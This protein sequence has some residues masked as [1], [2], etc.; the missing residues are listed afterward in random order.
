MARFRRVSR[1]SVILQISALT[2][3]LAGLIVTATAQSGKRLAALANPIM[4]AHDTTEHDTQASVAVVKVPGTSIVVSA[5]TNT[6]IYNLNAHKVGWSRSTD[7]G[8]TWTDQGHL[9][10][11]AN[12][13]GGEPVLAR[14]ATSGRIYLVTEA[15]AH[16]G[17]QVFRS[18]DNGATWLAPVNAFP[19]FTGD[20]FL[21]TPWIAVDNAVGT[22]QGN[23]YVIAKNIPGGGGGSQPAGSYVTRST[24][25]GATW[26]TAQSMTSIW[27]G[28][29]VAVGPDHTVYTFGWA[30]L[31]P[32]AIRLRRSTDFG[33]TFGS[34]ITVATL[35]GTSVDGDLGLS[36]GFKTNSNPHL[37]IDP[38]DN[39]LN[40]FY[41]DKNG[42]DKANI[43]VVSSGN[44]GLNWD[45][46]AFQI[47]NDTTGRDQ[48]NPSVAWTPDGRHIMVSW[49]DRR[50]DPG[51]SLIE[52]WGAIA[53][54][55]LDGE[56]CTLSPN[57]RVSTGSWP[58][59][60]NQD[61][62]IL[63]PTYM[64]KYDQ[65]T[66]VPGSF[67]V[68]WS[69]NRL[70]N[71][72]TSP[73]PHANQPDA[74][75]ASFLVNGP[76]RGDLDRDFQTD[77]TVFRPSS[78][79]ATAAVWGLSTDMDVLGDY[80]GDEKSDLAVFRPS[81]GQW[82]IVNSSDGAIRV[83][84]WG[85]NGDIPLAGDVDGDGSDDLVIFRPSAGAWYVLFSSGGFDA[86]NWGT[87]GDIPLLGDYVDDNS[88]DDLVIYRP[89]AGS[90]YA[91]S[92]WTGTSITVGW[93]VSTDIP[94]VGDFDGDRYA[95]PTIFRPSTGQ[96]FVKKSSG[97][98]IIVNW[99]VN[100]DIPVSGDWDGDA[101]SD[102]TVF[103]DTPG[104]WYSQLSTG[105]F[106]AVA[107]GTS[108]DKP[109]GR[110]PGS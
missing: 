5:F 20:D 60:V 16:A 61:S 9:P 35:S 68:G 4:N 56:C 37:H 62:F 69:D 23:V 26:S 52:R 84:Q 30:S 45:S 65:S 40:M 28:P 15:F 58:A 66:A 12:G 81:T 55:T 89:N 49:Y 22:G 27:V 82:F 85:T 13:D 92:P 48:W 2:A 103:R 25:G 87:S 76:P 90:W 10:D 75:F 39:Y 95:D 97:G 102:Y 98:T 34:F 17:A 19:A 38:V 77:R 33:V 64:G 88:A 46:Q 104:A 54:K 91:F 29:S 24:D 21:E 3:V 86:I 74:R 99:G 32:R 101:I 93:G 1:R 53:T 70:G 57:F 11:S 7:N 41:N 59:V 107:W 108:G 8:A 94:V 31:T 51:N 96:W 73:L 43:Y 42:T 79:G 14:D 106:A 83:V 72:G 44:G 36:G 71:N 47:N 100:G 109:A 105:G 6:A 67:G 78:G 110:R 50:S 18:T 63:S 80:D